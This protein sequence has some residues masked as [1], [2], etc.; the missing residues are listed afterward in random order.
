MILNDTLAELAK[1]AVH[2]ADG[3]FVKLEDVH[4]LFGERQEVKEEEAKK[5]KPKDFHEAK[6][7]AK[8][9]KELAKGFKKP[10]IVVDTPVAIEGVKS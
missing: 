5:P 7:L 3:S 4:R 1:V 9:D 6:A 8:D 10:P 2:T